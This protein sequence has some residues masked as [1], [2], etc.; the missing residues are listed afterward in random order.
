MQPRN[1]LKGDWKD[2][3]ILEK[4]LRDTDIFS[5]Q[6]LSLGLRID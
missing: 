2:S 5:C 6:M 3:S 1:E 4:D